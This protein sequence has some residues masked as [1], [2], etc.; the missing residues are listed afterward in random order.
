MRFLLCVVF[1]GACVSPDTPDPIDDTDKVDQEIATTP[2]LT[3]A[4]TFVTDGYVAA[5]ATD[6]T[7]LYMGGNFH[8][9]GE[10]SGELAVV[11]ADTGKR[12]KAITEL[13]GGGVAAIVA[14]GSGGYYVGGDFRKT[15]TFTTRA[16]AH[17]RAD[18]TWDPAWR[19]EI[20]G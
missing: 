18:G 8:Y 16:L 3:L 2:A 19:F 1:V 4:R 15:G 17:L 7:T 6:G 13:V 11:T 12:D 10:R 20:Q 9:I 5:A 14:D